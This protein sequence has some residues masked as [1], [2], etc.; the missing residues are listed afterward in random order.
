MSSNEMKLPLPKNTIVKLTLIGVL[1][2]SLLSVGLATQ[3]PTDS[4]EQGG[5]TIEADAPTPNEDFTPA[6][7]DDGHEEY[8][9]HEEYEDEDD[10]DD[11]EE[12]DEHEEYED[13]DD[14]DDHEEY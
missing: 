3:F 2:T 10:H 1:L 9:E 6:V 7:Q 11:H 4:P 13:E 12:Y 5:T 8:E 14:H